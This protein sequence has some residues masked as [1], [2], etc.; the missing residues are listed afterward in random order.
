MVRALLIP[1][2]SWSMATHFYQKDF[3][4]VVDLLGLRA[5]TSLRHIRLQVFPNEEDPATHLWVRASHFLAAVLSSVSPLITT[6][7]IV[8]QYHDVL[9]KNCSMADWEALRHVAG[10]SG[11]H[12]FSNLESVVFALMP[13]CSDSSVEM[14]AK[15]QITTQLPDLAKAGVLKFTTTVSSSDF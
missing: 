4:G 2:P 13:R 10:G 14:D 11:W 3:Q 8:L 5:C 15:H 6:V 12:K 7:T 1:A 9:L